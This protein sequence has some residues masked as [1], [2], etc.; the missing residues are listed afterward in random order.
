MLSPDQLRFASKH[1][2]VRCV[3]IFEAA[4]SSRHAVEPVPAAAVD[5]GNTA[6]VIVDSLKLLYYLYP[7][8][9]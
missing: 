7:S 9:I 3:T 1:Q 6:P 4:T 5:A 2:Q 8:S